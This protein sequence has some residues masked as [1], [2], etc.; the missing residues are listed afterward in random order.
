MNSGIAVP[1][2]VF[3]FTIR[4]IGYARPLHDTSTV[5]LSNSAAHPFKNRLPHPV[6][7]PKLL[8]GESWNINTNTNHE[9]GT[10]KIGVVRP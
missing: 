5:F 10:F 7:G 3:H 2:H 9:A 1:C 4:L 6:S 8:V